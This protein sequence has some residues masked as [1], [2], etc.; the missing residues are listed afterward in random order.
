[1]LQLEGTSLMRRAVAHQA[2]ATASRRGNLAALHYSEL[3]GAIHSGTTAKTD[4]S[5]SDDEYRI[6]KP[7]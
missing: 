3:N 7:P 1:M 4:S 5:D 6:S 2:G